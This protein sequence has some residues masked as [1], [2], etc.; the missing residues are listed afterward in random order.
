MRLFL[1]IVV[2]LV[3]IGC[4]SNS[5]NQDENESKKQN[6]SGPSVEKKNAS[7][8]TK[9]NANTNQDDKATAQTAKVLTNSI[10]MEFKPIPAGTFTMGEGDT[11]HQVTLKKSFEMGVFEVTQEQ[12][13]KVMGKNPSKFKGANNPV[14]QVSWN[15]AVEFCRKLSELREE[16]TAGHVYRL[17]TEAEWEYACRSGTSTSYSFG[18][19]KSELG[20]YAWYKDNSGEKTHPVGKKKPNAW[21]LYDMH[22]NVFEWCQDYYGQP[23]TDPATDPMGPKSGSDRVFRGGAATTYPPTAAFRRAAAATSRRPVAA[24]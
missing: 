20:E 16:N 17:P 19:D 23:S 12:Y 10:G 9:S 2:L 5:S 1:S 21:G 22:G 4:G 24:S 3:F 13:E 7:N 6:S 14:E 8:E 18:N 11:A 15:D